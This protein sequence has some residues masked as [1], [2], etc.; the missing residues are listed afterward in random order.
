MARLE[1]VEIFGPSHRINQRLYVPRAAI[2]ASAPA[3]VDAAENF[4]GTAA[5]RGEG[6]TITQ[7]ATRFDV[8]PRLKVEEHALRLTWPELESAVSERAKV[9]VLATRATAKRRIEGKSANGG[10]YIVYR[11]RIQ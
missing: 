5:R 7:H 11:A 9:V 8:H 1:C 2:G 6:S 10:E 3:E 4:V